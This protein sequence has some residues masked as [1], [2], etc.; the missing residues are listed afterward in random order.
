LQSGPDE[1]NCPGI[2]FDV[3]EFTFPTDDENDGSNQEG[4]EVMKENNSSNQER[5]EL[6]E[7]NNCSN[8]EGEEKEVIADSDSDQLESDGLE[9][10]DSELRQG[11][12]R[13]CPECGTFY[14]RM[15]HTCEYKIKPFACNVCGKRCVDEK[16]LKTHCA[17]HKESYEY[18]CKYCLVPFKTKLDKLAHEGTHVL[19]AKPYTCPDCSMMFAK[20]SARNL[21]LKGHRGPKIFPC[22]HCALEFRYTYALERHVVVHT[23][24]KQFVCV[25]CRRSFSQAGHL[26]SHLRVHTGEK[27]YQC[28]HCDKSF[29]H[30]VSLKSHITRYHTGPF[31]KMVPPGAMNEE[32]TTRDVDMD[33]DIIDG[34]PKRKEPMKKIR[35]TRKRS[36]GRPKGRPKRNA[37][38]GETIS[39]TAEQGDALEPVT[40]SKRLEEGEDLM[41]SSSKDIEST[42]SDG[43]STSELAEEDEAEESKA[44]KKSKQ[45][46]SQR[47][48]TLNIA[49]EDFDSDSDFDPAEEAKKRRTS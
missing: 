11:V 2:T 1:E 4:V 32:M 17:I 13:L 6:L 15:T 37:V 43:D 9:V 47:P 16:A 35:K 38:M 14:Y 46:A 18:P 12:R 29:N 48:N 40:V 8:E 44:V 26:K 25:F 24:M 34:D 42:C 33:E 7:E 27:P 28:Q 20:L 3:S 30:N 49:E 45:K 41:R 10:L 31:E 21:H 23:G 19:S 5:V 39:I 22:P 36:S